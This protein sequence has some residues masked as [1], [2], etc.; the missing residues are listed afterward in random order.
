VRRGIVHRLDEHRRVLVRGVWIGVAIGVPANVLAAWAF[1]RWE[2]LPPSAGGLAGV[3]GQAIG[4]PLLAVGYACAIVLLSLAGS[5]FVR[6]FAPVGRMALTNYLM[7]SVI[8]VVLSY[9]FGFGLW[10]RVNVTTAFAIA[11]A[12]VLTQLV[13]SAV[14]LRWFQSGPAEWAWRRLTYR[15]PLPIRRS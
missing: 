14:W 6:M 7:Q 5:R 12:I 1:T 2:Y 4:V 8:C 11:A 10:W 9:G 15:R 3:L 13:T